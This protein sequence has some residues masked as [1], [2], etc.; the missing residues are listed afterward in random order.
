[1]GVS[2][3]FGL[4][5]VALYALAFALWLAPSLGPLKIPVA[6]YMCAITAMVITAIRSRFGRRVASGA[7]LFLVSDSLLAVAKFQ[8]PFT[9][10]DYLVWA[11]YYAAQYLIATGALRDLQ[12]G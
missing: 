3:R 6:L 8:A 9:W 7:M 1:M 12:N 10:H 11:T 4:A 2:H 5:G